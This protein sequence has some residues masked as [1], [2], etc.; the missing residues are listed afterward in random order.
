MEDVRQVAEAT[1]GGICAFVEGSSV[2]RFSEA[3]SYVRF[4]GSNSGSRVVAQFIARNLNRIC[5]NGSNS[6]L[7]LLLLIKTLFYITHARNLLLAHTLKQK[8][9]DCFKPHPVSP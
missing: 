4:C 9:I 5:H 2:R 1:V 7:L 8:I 3:T 6:L